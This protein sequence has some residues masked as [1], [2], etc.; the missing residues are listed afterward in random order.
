MPVQSLNFI[1]A[2]WLVK[3]DSLRK[4]WSVLSTECSEGPTQQC[5][6]ST[7][8][9]FQICHSFA[10]SFGHCSSIQLL[11]HTNLNLAVA[12]W[13]SFQPKKVTSALP[14]GASEDGGWLSGL[15]SS[16][17]QKPDHS[18]TTLPS[19]QQGIAEIF[20]FQQSPRWTPPSPIHLSKNSGFKTFLRDLVGS[21]WQTAETRKI[22]EHV[23]SSCDSQT[24]ELW[25]SICTTI[26]FSPS[27]WCPPCDLHSH[28]HLALPPTNGH[29]M[30]LSWVANA[31]PDRPDSKFP[32][33]N[34]HLSRLYQD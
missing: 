20:L 21:I 6:C 22:P 5:P 8:F 7:F 26:N 31:F 25:A 28:S 3:S 34:S 9:L 2:I 15:N 32:S 17:N 27:F 12:A 19:P 4:K 1:K 16:L 13:I 23:K 11:A 29:Q 30:L 24:V 10:A 33:Q 18:I 14:S